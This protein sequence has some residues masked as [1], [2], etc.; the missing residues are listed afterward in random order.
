MRLEPCYFFSFFFGFTD[1][2]SKL[3]LRTLSLFKS[4]L[5]VVSVVKLVLTGLNRS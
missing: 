1:Y 3:L 2:Y 5:L 4:S